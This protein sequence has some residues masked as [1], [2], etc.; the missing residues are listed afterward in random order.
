MKLV[1]FFLGRKGSGPVYSFEMA[2]ALSS[3]AN[4]LLVL[5]NEI[6]NK[7]HWLEVFSSKENVSIKFF[8]TYNNKLSFL[9]NSLNIFN[10]YRIINAI[11]FYKPDAIYAPFNHLWSPLIFPFLQKNNIYSTLHDVK[12]HLGE[13]IFFSTIQKLNLKLVHRIIILNN[14]D[15]DN[16]LKLNF[17]E[18]NICVI[19]HAAFSYYNKKEL[20]SKKVFSDKLLF[21]GRIE[22]YKGLDL[23]LDAFT[24][25]LEKNPNLKLTIAGI[26]VLKDYHHKIQYLKKSIIVINKWLSEDEI[27]SLVSETDV[28]VLPYLGA[29]Q[30]G[31][32]P[33]AYGFGKTVIATNVGSLQEQVPL[34]TGLIVEPNVTKLFEAI[35]YLFSNKEVIFEYS[36]NAKKY[37]DEFMSWD[38]SA[39]LLLSFIRKTNN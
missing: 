36:S 11:K 35:N 10:Y 37:A 27:Q 32:I 26:G 5:S 34:G 16:V 2:N 17:S 18:E 19:P 7:Q 33:L 9:F 39:D 38:K 23:L 22:K 28:V 1:L 31:I 14:K 6:E 30:S 12:V 3:Q 8:K 4:L 15:V 20:K 24:L 25:A 29:S 21:I 13:N